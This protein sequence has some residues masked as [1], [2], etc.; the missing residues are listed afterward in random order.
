MSYTTS[1]FSPC[2]TYTASNPA[3]LRVGSTTPILHSSI[4]IA[5]CT[6]LN[7]SCNPDISAAQIKCQQLPKGGHSANSSITNPNFPLAY[8]RLRSTPPSHHLGKS[9]IQT[10]VPENE[11]IQSPLAWFLGCLQRRNGHATREG[12]PT[13][14]P[15]G[16]FRC[17]TIHYHGQV[18][19]VSPTH[20]R[21]ESER[22]AFLIMDYG[23]MAEV[24][25]LSSDRLRK[26]APSARNVHNDSNLRHKPSV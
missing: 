5:T 2:C 12:W 14:R 23:G 8:P 6:T 10:Q 17:E 11:D 16:C 4:L 24:C 3:Q 26:P 20:V 22:C 25:L 7:S 18:T 21:I 9:K 19:P 13:P 1:T 15:V